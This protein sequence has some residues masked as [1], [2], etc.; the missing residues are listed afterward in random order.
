MKGPVPYTVP[1]DHLGQKHNLGMQDHFLHRRHGWQIC[2]QDF[3]ARNKLLEKYS[4]TLGIPSQRVYLLSVVRVK[5]DGGTCSP[6]SQEA[7]VGKPLEFTSSRST[8]ATKQDPISNKKKDC[9]S[10]LCALLVNN[11]TEINLQQ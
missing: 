2:F 5:Q 10:E 7:E 6:A 9:Q 8:Y 3:S 11:G 1:A 4:S